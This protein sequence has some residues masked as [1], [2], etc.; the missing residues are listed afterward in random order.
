MDIPPFKVDGQSIVLG[1]EGPEYQK[2]T[3]T[4]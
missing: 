2:M 3:A 4:A 1:E